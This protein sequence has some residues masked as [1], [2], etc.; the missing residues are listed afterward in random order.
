ML[1]GSMAMSL[2]SPTLSP[3]LS[4]PLYF[5]QKNLHILLLIIF[6]PCPL[7]FP[8]TLSFFHFFPFSCLPA[9]SLCF[10]QASLCQSAVAMCRSETSPRA[11]VGLTTLR[12]ASAGDAV[13]RGLMSSSRY[14][15]ETSA[16]AHTLNIRCH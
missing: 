8:S 4:F 5:L 12:S 9:S 13:C 6:F 3:P 14:V 16:H 15:K 2:C 1:R 7:S 11:T 10:C